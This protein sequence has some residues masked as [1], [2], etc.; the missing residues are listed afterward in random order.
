MLKII[1]KVEIKNIF[2]IILNMFFVFFNDFFSIINDMQHIT[3]MLCS[4]CL[5]KDYF[6]CKYHNSLTFH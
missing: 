4:T 3:P 2:I 5:F 6:L 1:Y